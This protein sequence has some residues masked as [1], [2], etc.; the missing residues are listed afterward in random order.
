[1]ENNSIN[2]P[3]KPDK[4]DFNARLQYELYKQLIIFTT[5]YKLFDENL[6]EENLDELLKESREE[7]TFLTEKLE[8]VQ[9]DS[10]LKK[11]EN[12]QKLRNSDEKIENDPK[13][14]ILEI[15]EK[16]QKID[17]S[18]KSENFNFKFLEKKISELKSK[19]LA[20]LQDYEKI[21]DFDVKFDFSMENFDEF[22]FENLQIP[23][24]KLEIPEKYSLEKFD[25]LSEDLIEEFKEEGIEESDLKMRRSAEKLYEQLENLVKN[26]NNLNSQSIFLEEKIKKLEKLSEDFEENE[27]IVQLPKISKFDHSKIS[28]FL[29]L[30][31]QK[32]N[33][34]NSVFSEDS[35]KT[36]DLFIKMLR[37][38]KIGVYNNNM[39]YLHEVFN[40]KSAEVE[41]MKK[42]LE[43]SPE[44]LQAHQ[45]DLDSDEFESRCN[46]A[47]CSICRQ[48]LKNCIL[49]NCGH[50]FCHSCITTRYNSRH[51][52]CPECKKPIM[53]IN[54]IKS[55]KLE[56]NYSI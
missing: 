31:G 37:N 38:Y 47:R 33:E 36:Q 32:I 11:Y 34:L 49:E 3:E 30:F 22:N 2:L 42:L 53:S 43:M 13:I 50:S 41:N 8:K 25:F 54:Q 14:L 29:E 18:F 45:R 35:L 20:D 56:E 5:S 21:D 26:L 23:E 1:M 27:K 15:F 9:K 55:F 51:R 24:K 52:S 48:K 4:L 7:I 6:T 10:D 44:E 39:K 46:F 28:S 19:I 12:M 40:A 16:L 17:E